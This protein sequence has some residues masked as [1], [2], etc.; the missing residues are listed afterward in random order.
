[1][2]LRIDAAYRWDTLPEGAVVVDIGSGI[3]TVSYPLAEAYPHL[4]IVNQDL[5][6]VIENAKPVRHPS[7]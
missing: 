1:M 3:G 7:S 6:S 2:G 5:P 4:Q